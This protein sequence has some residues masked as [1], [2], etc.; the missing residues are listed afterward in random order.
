MIDKEKKIKYVFAIDGHAGAGKSTVSQVVA[1]QLDLLHVNT[2]LFYRAITWAILKAEIE[3]N[4]SESLEDFVQTLN[5]KSNLTEHQELLVMIDGQDISSFIRS[6]EVNQS[7]SIISAYAFV[8][9]KV[10]YLLRKIKHPHGLVMEGRDIGSAVFPDALAKV[11]LTASVDERA[12]RRLE[13]VMA[14]GEK[15]SLENIKASILKRDKIDSERKVAP[16]VLADDAVLIDTT[17][18]SRED[19]IDRMV[20]IWR[21]RKKDAEKFES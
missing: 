15:I 10:N 19:V 16:L 7:I 18:L 21:L 12:Q 11:F 5:L 17:E 8:R 6:D 2:G 20:T 1:E 13:D 14:R 3:L 4:D 9:D